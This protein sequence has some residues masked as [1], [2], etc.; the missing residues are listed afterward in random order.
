MEIG[1]VL[2]S[3]GVG[4]RLRPLTEAV[5]KPAIPILD[6]PLGA[7]GLKDLLIAA[8][9]VIVNVSHLPETVLE[10]LHP[11]GGGG[12][13][14]AMDE[15]PEGYGTAGTLAHLGDQIKE[16]VVVRN[17]DAYSDATAADVLET[18]FHSGASVT[19]AVQEVETEADLRVDGGKAVE[20]IDRRLE[21]NA[22][23]ARYIG[24]AVLEKGAV[25]QIPQ[26]RPL[27]LGESVFR[28]LVEKGEVA[29]HVHEGYSLDVGT[30]TRY[31]EASADALTGRA[32]HPLTGWP[33]V[34][35]AHSHY[36]GFGAEVA[37]GTLGAGAI[38]LSGAR[39]ESGAF[40]EHAVVWPRE[41][42]PSGTR[43][44]NGV[45]FNGKNLQSL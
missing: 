8:P 24:I 45:Y 10:A 14:V 9:P 2:F 25:A 21:P 17:A 13:W 12:D 44:T 38:V 11:W 5:A 30:L 22:G 15:G 23:G 31:L 20:F 39:V 7:F 28:P 41:A 27:G 43:V 1:S 4:K 16:R 42:L 34:H 32:P 35:E 3:A 29:V 40:V 19:L 33:G 37:D 26:T 18:H 36:I 6:V